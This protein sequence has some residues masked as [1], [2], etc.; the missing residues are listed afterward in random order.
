MGV[1]CAI[2]LLHIFVTRAQRVN[3]E[4]NSVACIDLSGV[5]IAKNI[6]ILINISVKG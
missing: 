1:Y 3:H 6:T 5:D 4:T 2:H